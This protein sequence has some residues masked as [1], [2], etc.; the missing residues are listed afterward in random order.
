MGGSRAGQARRACSPFAKDPT[1]VKGRWP[2]KNGAPIAQ[3][4]SGAGPQAEEQ[5]VYS[6][7]TR[8]H[9][10]GF[11]VCKIASLCSFVE[12]AKESSRTTSYS[13]SRRSK[14]AHDSTEGCVT[15]IGDTADVQAADV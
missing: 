4:E 14:V 9:L 11:C 6:H 8:C 7:A 2:V 13:S 1:E 15:G 10:V 5:Y 12:S 3:R